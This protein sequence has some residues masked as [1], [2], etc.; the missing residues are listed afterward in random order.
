MKSIYPHLVVCYLLATF[1][2]WSRRLLA[3]LVLYPR[4]R[5]LVYDISNG[6]SSDIRCSFDLLFEYLD[7]WMCWLAFYWNRD[8][9]K[10]VSFLSMIQVSEAMTF[11]LT[12]WP[13]NCVL[14]GHLYWLN[15]EYV[16]VN[17]SVQRCMS[18]AVP[19]YTWFFYGTR[20]FTFLIFFFTF[21]CQ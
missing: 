17:Q 13:F 8:M 10:S 3:R 15:N 4:Y 5:C 12:D 1:M 21:K 14:L 11:L 6:V 7:R 2:F 18:V 19:T 9:M 16:G 20:F